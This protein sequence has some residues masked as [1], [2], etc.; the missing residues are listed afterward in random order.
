MW[1]EDKLIFKILQ[2]RVPLSI[3][4]YVCVSL[5]AEAK[6]DKWEAFFSLFDLNLSIWIL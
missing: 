6:Y 2:L 1:P 5:V 4:I 3:W